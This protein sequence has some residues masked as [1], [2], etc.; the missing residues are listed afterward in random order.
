IGGA[1]PAALRRA[2]QRGDG[3]IEIGCTDLDELAAK[4]GVIQDHRRQAGR[5]DLPFEFTA[6]VGTDLDDIR[7]ARDLGVTRIVAGATPVNGRVSAD[8]VRDFTARFA[9][10][11]MARL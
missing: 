6:G 5:Q 10:E 11:V 8:D 3:W 4:I 7:R 2:G 1:S 9:D